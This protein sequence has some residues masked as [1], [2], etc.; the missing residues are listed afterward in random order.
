M[1]HDKGDSPKETG[2]SIAARKRILILGRDIAGLLFDKLPADG[3]DVKW[4][5]YLGGPLPVEE[6]YS[7]LSTHQY[8]L[9]LVTLRN[10]CEL[11]FVIRRQF[12]AVK[13]IFANSQ[14][15]EW[16]LAARKH[17]VHAVLPAPFLYDELLDEIRK[18][19]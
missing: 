16:T 13:T 17:G 1:I 8:D 6:V 19:I 12:P 10:F 9:V 11:L 3:Y 4:I 18:L 2:S 5:E 14:N 15:L 7:E